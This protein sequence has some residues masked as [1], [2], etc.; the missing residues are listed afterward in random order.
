MKRILPIA[1]LLLL[2]PIAAHAQDAAAVPDQVLQAFRGATAGFAGPLLSLAQ[3]TFFVLAGIS[4]AWAVLKLALQRADMSEILAAV[5]NQLFFIGIF[6][7]AMNAWTTWAPLIIRSFQYA[8]GQAGGSTFTPGGVVSAGVAIATKV[9]AQTSLFRPGDSVILG[10][11]GLLVLVCFALVAIEM[12]IAL[13]G[14]TSSH[15]PASSFC[16]S[17]ALCGRAT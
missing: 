1:G 8:A 6:E 2:L 5:V 4:F 17:A 11:C 3:D 9:W 10:F 7:W 13:I 15:M 14:R 12:V 16:C